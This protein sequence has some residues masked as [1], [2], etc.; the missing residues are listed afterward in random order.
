MVAP[1]LFILCRKVV[2]VL[3]AKLVIRI[4]VKVEIVAFNSKSCR[5]HLGITRVF[6][7]AV[8]GN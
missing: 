8:A 2:Y 4:V 5:A 7:M 1:D 3:I 6:V